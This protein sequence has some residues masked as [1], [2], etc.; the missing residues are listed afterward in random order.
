MCLFCGALVFCYLCRRKITKRS[1]KGQTILGKVMEKTDTRRVIIRIGRHHLSFT[2]FGVAEDSS[3]DDNPIRYEPYVMRSGISMA[4]NLREAMADSRG[5][6]EK[7]TVMF[8]VPIMLIPAKQFELTT[9]EAM[10]RQAFPKKEKEQ[11]EVLY[12]EISELNVV[13]VFAV[14]KDVYTVLTDNFADVKAVAA[15]VPVWGHLYRHSLTGTRRKLYGYFHDQKLDIFAFQQNRFK[16]Y[17]QFETAR[18]HDA[19]Y[20]L[21]YVWNQLMFDQ[22]HDELYIVGEI[23]ERDWLMEELK[24]YVQKTYAINPSSDFNRTPATQVRN[25]PYDLMTLLSKWR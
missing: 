9:M 14:N 2:R 6:E 8:D 13:S 22:E 12:N 17:N 24:G 11:E 20:F 21:L 25:I 3:S 15:L 23:P 5:R 19:L 18:S 7:A 4:A 10:F 1:V 16:F